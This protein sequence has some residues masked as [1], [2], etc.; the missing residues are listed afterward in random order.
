MDDH[1][2]ARPPAALEAILG[3]TAALGF[4]MA[5]EPKT[6]ALLKVLAA[7][8]PG[9]RIL[10]IGTGTGVGTSWLLDGMNEGAHLDTV[11]SDAMVSAVARRHLGSDSRV[12]FHLADGAEFVSRSTP[13]RFDLI[14]ADAWPGKFSH[15]D[16]ALSLLRLGGMYLID[17]LLPQTNWP[18]GHALKVPALISDLESRSAFV[19]V[20]LS[21]ASGLMILVRQERAKDPR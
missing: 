1:I 3:D 8:K 14:Y 2:V 4:N 11:D 5:S 16:Q 7:S 9:G 12:T 20:K 6:G 13:E 17:D 15:L 21:W 10:E 19:S 18:D